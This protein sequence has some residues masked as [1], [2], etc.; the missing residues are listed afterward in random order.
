M[1]AV[2]NF[3]FKVVNSNMVLPN[4]ILVF[5]PKYENFQYFYWFCL[6]VINQIQNK[7][8]FFI[9]SLTFT[10]DTSRTKLELNIVINYPLTCRHYVYYIQWVIIALK[11]V[12]N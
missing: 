1:K 11:H 4:F 7:T 10:F 12:H 5:E 2:G 9:E 8:T 6:T 3:Y